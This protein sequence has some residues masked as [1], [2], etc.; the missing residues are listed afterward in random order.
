[1][2]VWISYDLIGKDESSEDYK[3]LIAKIKTLGNTKKIEYS[4]WV[5]DTT[6]SPEEVR[7]LLRSSLDA[8]DTLIVMKR[9]GGSAW[10]NLPADVSQWLKD[11]PA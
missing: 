3:K 1:M 10:R 6:L 9:V 7:D 2:G 5:S 8:D 4:L 11:H